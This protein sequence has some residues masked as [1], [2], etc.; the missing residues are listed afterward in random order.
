MARRNQLIL[1]IGL[2]IALLTTGVFASR[3][4]RHARHLREHAST[5]PVQPWMNVAFISHSYLVPPPE[6][7]KAL[8]I[9]PGPD[10]RLPLQR[11]AR[12]QN[13]SS[14]E[15]VADV[16]RAIKAWREAH[17]PPPKPPGLRPLPTPVPGTST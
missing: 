17:P 3:V 9:K 15:V 11:I 4:M 1:A 8:H 7:V 16:E 14:A 2:M 6:L 10:E 12:M 5:D 13:R